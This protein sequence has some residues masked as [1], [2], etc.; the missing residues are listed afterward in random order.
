MS[1]TSGILLHPTSLPG[2]PICGNFGAPARNWLRLLARHGIGVWQFLPLSPAD[3]TGSPYSSPSG[4]AFN[5]FF[6]DV[7]ELVDKDFLSSSSVTSLPVALEGQDYFVDFN[8]AQLR[9]DKI[10]LLLVNA[11]EEQNSQK[12]LEFK[13]WCN[14]QFWLDD[15]ATFMELRRQNDGLPWWEWPAEFSRYNKKKI[16]EWSK[17]NA[18]ELLGHCLI[19]WHLD[20]QW[21]SLRVL[22]KEL[23]VFLFGDMPFYVARD[24]ADVW[25]N[26]QLFSVLINGKTHLQS[27]VPPDYFS[28]TG[29]LWGNPVYRWSR[30]KSTH[31]QWWRNRFARHLDQVDFLRLDHFRALEAY[32]AIPGEDKTAENGFWRPSPGLELLKLI[33]RDCGNRLPLIAED[34]GVITTAVENLR[35]YFKLPGMKILQFAFDGNTDNPYLPGNIIGE[36]WIVYTGTHDNSTTLGWWNSM[37]NNNKEMIKSHFKG[38]DSPS[39]ELIKLGMGTEAKLFVAPIQ[40]LLGLDDSAR[41]NKPGTSQNNWSW[42]FSDELF[43]LEKSLISFGELSLSFNRKKENAAG[44]I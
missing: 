6:L 12:H 23:G 29:Q 25:S 30:H 32:W 27:G 36:N 41:F 10:R 11:W 4:F 2:S 38:I 8:L 1:K 16:K 20:R 26:R 19:Q 9:V 7:N 21:Q 43:R 18:R 22:A 13:S 42:R 24:S 5:P 33:Q 35:D 40:D 3:S 44:L 31:Y 28:N 37:E 14:N 17:T 15:H 34:L 39:W